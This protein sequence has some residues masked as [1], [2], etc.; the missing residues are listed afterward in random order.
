MVSNMQK[1]IPRSFFPQIAKRLQHNPVVALLGPRQTGKST[2]AKQII[3]KY[4]ESIYLDLEK[5]SDRLKLER[6]PEFFLRENRN[7]LICLDEIQLLP[8]IFSTL[9]SFV[10]ESGKNAQFLIL[11]SAS[12]DLIRQSSE[13][14]A[15]RIAYIEITPFHLS[16]VKDV[17]TVKNHW[18]QGGYPK[19]LLQNDLEESFSWRENYIKTFLERDLPQLG[20]N[21]PAKILER[22]WTMLAHNH[23]QLVNYSNL[24]KSLGVTHHT[25]KSYIDILEQ[26]FILRTLRPYFSNEKKRLVKSSKVYLRDTGL[27]HTLLNLE[28]FNSLLGH[29]I[30]GTSYESYVIENI[31]A[32]AA[33]WRPTFYRDSVG[34]EI[35]LLLEKGDRKIAIEVKSSTSPKI[36][37]GFWNAVNF[38]QPEQKW[39]ISHVDEKFST[40]EGVIITNLPSFLKEVDLS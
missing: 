9:R 35:D 34:N 4:P 36:E 37:K 16:E 24:G 13:T 17:T 18:L 8:E 20:F 21:I 33:R 40:R 5:K 29:P 23:G 3:K 27:L 32:Q 22:F 19:A 12:R 39:I 6:D 11:G 28:D 38:I 25:I 15:G 10:D 7:R 31:L 1:Y 14:L 2:L 26:T 30:F